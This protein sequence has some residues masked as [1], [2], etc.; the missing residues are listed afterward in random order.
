MLVVVVSREQR[1]FDD[2]SALSCIGKEVA[3]ALEVLVIPL[4]EVVFLSSNTAE[5]LY[6][7]GFFGGES[8]FRDTKGL[9]GNF[10]VH[11]GKRAGEVQVVEGQRIE[12]LAEL[13][14]T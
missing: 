2:D 1:Y 12:V 7:I 11:A 4:G 14:A 9:A 8:V 3:P 6:E 10:P 5:R 13:E